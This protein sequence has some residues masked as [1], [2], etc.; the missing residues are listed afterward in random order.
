MHLH[1]DFGTLVFSDL[2]GHVTSNKSSFSFG[3]YEIQK[4]EGHVIAKNDHM[5]HVK[6]AV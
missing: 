4:V 6:M 1:A 2:T 3:P 5:V